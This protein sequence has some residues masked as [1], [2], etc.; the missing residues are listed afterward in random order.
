[1]Q[2]RGD[3]KL[4]R[5]PTSNKINITDTIIPEYEK[6]AITHGGLIHSLHRVFEI[7]VALTASDWLSKGLDLSRVKGSTYGL[8]GIG[9][10]NGFSELDSG[11]GCFAFDNTKMLLS[12]PLSKS[13]RCGLSALIGKLKEH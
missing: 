3:R 13:A 10:Y 12:S 1:M 4:N 8:S 7:T 11:Y 9:F 6:P 2:Q 5:K